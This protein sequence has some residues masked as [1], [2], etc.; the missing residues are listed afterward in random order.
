MTGVV[1]QVTEEF[2]NYPYLH[3]LEKMSNILNQDLK[4]EMQ[5]MDEYVLCHMGV[6][7]VVQNIV[8]RNFLKTLEPQEETQEVVFVF[9]QKIGF[10][11]YGAT[12]LKDDFMDPEVV[13]YTTWNW[14]FAFL[15][16]KLYPVEPLQVYPYCQDTVGNWINIDNTVPPVKKGQFWN[17]NAFPIQI[18]NI[19]LNS[20]NTTCQEEDKRMHREGKSNYCFDK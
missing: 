14:V 13:H 6:E 5:D 3:P 16:L 1:R 18:K 12:V 8:K 15:R 10:S 17:G 9:L 11:E 4:N 19:D 7:N 2:A 20:L